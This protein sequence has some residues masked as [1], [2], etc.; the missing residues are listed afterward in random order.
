LAVD[1]GAM[2]MGA[3]F[4]HGD[5]IG[6]GQLEDRGHTGGEP[7]VTPRWYGTHR[8]IA[9]GRQSEFHRGRELCQGQSAQVE[10]GGSRWLW[11]R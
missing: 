11:R 7:G 3:V 8:A 2:G 9:P 6:T 10:R 1:A 5:A 4:D